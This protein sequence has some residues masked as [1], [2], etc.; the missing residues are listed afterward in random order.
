MVLLDPV[1]CGERKGVN[2]QDQACVL[3]HKALERKDLLDILLADGPLRGSQL[4]TR[5]ITLQAGLH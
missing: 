5:E 1:E 3:N 2:L 4:G